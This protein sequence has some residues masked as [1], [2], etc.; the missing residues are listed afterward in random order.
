M[1]LSETVEGS[2]CVCNNGGGGEGGSYRCLEEYDMIWGRKKRWK[3][4]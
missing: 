2:A 3:M 1:T 4:Y